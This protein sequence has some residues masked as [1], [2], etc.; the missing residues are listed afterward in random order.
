MTTVEPHATTAAPTAP[1]QVALLDLP[2]DRLTED[3]VIDR[4]LEGVKA[5]RGGW[6]CPVNL[7]VLRK[8]T[9]DPEL[10]T[11]VEGADLVVA[12]GMPLVWASKI[13]GTTAARACRG[14]FPRHDAARGRR[15]G[16]THRSSS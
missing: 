1:E 4:V 12:D 8:V 16:Q 10:R 14:F 9:R 5:G 7:D 13:Q 3:E 2:L 15:S 6:I 11:L